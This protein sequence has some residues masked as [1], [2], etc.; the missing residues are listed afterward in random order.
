[1]QVLAAA[2]DVRAHLD[3]LRAAALTA[4]EYRTRSDLADDLGTRTALLVPR[5][6]P[7]RPATGNDTRTTRRDTTPAPGPAEMAPPPSSTEDVTADA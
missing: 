2:D 4:A 6:R 3:E 7:S 1:M 5:T